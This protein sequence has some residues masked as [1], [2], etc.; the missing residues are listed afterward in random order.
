MTGSTFLHA[1][2]ANQ[3]TYLKD[4]TLD[5]LAIFLTL[6]FSLGFKVFIHLSSSNHVLHKHS[7]DAEMHLTLV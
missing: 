1:R 7:I 2:Q 3:A 4:D 6:F 5:H